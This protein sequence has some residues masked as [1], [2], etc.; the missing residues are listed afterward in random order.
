[1]F[2]LTFVLAVQPQ[3]QFALLIAVAAHIAVCYWV[4]RPIQGVGIAMPACASPAVA[5]GV[6]WLLLM[7]QPVS[8][9]M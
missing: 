4:A 6:V 3:A 8:K 2:E 5:V 7:P 9:R 1:M